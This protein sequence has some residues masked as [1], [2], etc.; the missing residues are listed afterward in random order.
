[1]LAHCTEKFR[2]IHFVSFSSETI[3]KQQEAMRLRFHQFYAI[4]GTQNFHKVDESAF[5]QF[6]QHGLKWKE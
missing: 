5:I 1:M 4:K 3:A 2:S 6:I